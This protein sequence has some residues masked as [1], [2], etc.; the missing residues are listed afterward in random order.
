VLPI[1][2]ILMHSIA[3]IFMLFIGKLQYFLYFV[4]MF[5]IEVDHSILSYSHTLIPRSQCLRKDENPA[6]PAV[7]ALRP[8]SFRTR[9]VP[10]ITHLN[11][12]LLSVPADELRDLMDG[13]LLPWPHTAQL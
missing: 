5:I 12:S 8:S 2:L 3:R 7:V 6:P 1:S 11:T 13:H 4:M 10:A 9:L